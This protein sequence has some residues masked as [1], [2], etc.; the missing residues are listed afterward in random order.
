MIRNVE[1]EN[2]LREF[3]EHVEIGRSLASV[4]KA[5]SMGV[6]PVSL[7]LA[8]ALAILREFRRSDVTLEEQDHSFYVIHLEPDV[9]D[10]DPERWIIVD[11]T[12]PLFRRLRERHHQ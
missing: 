2:W 7:T 3:D 6:T 9:E 5:R 1:F 10:P 4:I 12:S 11:S 8:G